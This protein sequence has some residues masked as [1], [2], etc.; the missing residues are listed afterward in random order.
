MC[1][2]DGTKWRLTQLST[3]TVS[4]LY[5]QRDSAIPNPSVRPSVTRWHLVRPN[6]KFSHRYDANRSRS[7][8]YITVSNLTVEIIA[9]MRRPT[10]VIDVMQYTGYLVPCTFSRPRSIWG[11]AASWIIFRHC[12][13]SSTDLSKP[14]PVSPVHLVMLSCRRVLCLPLFYQK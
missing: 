5:A 13:L 14:S 6:K 2:C 4:K 9:H 3:F 12:L 7:A 11:L 8:S 1:T 10:I